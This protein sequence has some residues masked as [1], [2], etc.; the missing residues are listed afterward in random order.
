RRDARVQAGRLG[1]GVRGRCRVVGRRRGGGEVPGGAREGRRVI[2]L[3]GRAE[4]RVVAQ[5]ERRLAGPLEPRPVPDG[6]A[7]GGQAAGHEGQHD[8]RL[9]GA[10]LDRQPQPLGR[11]PR[12]GGG[13]PPPPR[14]PSHHPA[15]PGGAPGGGGG[16]LVPRPRPQGGADRVG[17]VG[18]GSVRQR[19]PQDA[20]VLRVQLLPRRDLGRGG[21]AG[22][23]G[24]TVAQRGR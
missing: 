5:Q 22:G 12:G 24:V 9:S 11:G 18:G 17:G 3:V 13:G 14:A 20:E 16:A 21:R 15:G 8:F 1:G 4:L 23:E 6:A 7:A 19:P 2:D 10:R